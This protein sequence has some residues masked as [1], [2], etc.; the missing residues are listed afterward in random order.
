V[1]EKMLPVRQV[2][3]LVEALA[4]AVHH[5]HE[6]GVVHRSLKPASVLL[7]P[8]DKAERDRPADAPPLPPFLALHS[9]QYVP[10]ITDFGLARRAAATARRWSWPRTCAASARVT[11][12]ASAPPASPSASANGCGAGRRLWWPCCY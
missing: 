6:R 11:P 8:R 4:R 3:P 7:L 9:A 1:G 2:L 10:K 12:P 5:A